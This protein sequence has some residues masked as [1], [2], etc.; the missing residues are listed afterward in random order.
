MIQADEIREKARKWYPSFLLSYLKGK[1]FFPK[2]IRFRKPGSSEILQNYLKIDKE[3]QNLLA[4]SKEAKGFGYT[5]IRTE[6][7]NHKLG[8]QLFPTRIYFET[9]Q[10]YLKFIRQEKDFET[11]IKCVELLRTE[12][13]QIEDW[14]LQHR[15]EITGYADRWEYLLKV[16][17][18][19]LMTPRPHQYLRELNIQV[20]TKFIEDNTGILMSLLDYLL[21]EEHIRNP[22]EK[23]NFAKRY[24]LKYSEELIRFRVLNAESLNDQLFNL[25]DLS[26]P[27][28]QFEQLDFPCK[29]V[30]VTENL[31]NF[32]TLPSY[33]D[34]I[35]IFGGG[36]HISL[37]KNTRWLE[38]KEIFY[39]GDIDTHG[40]QILS[41]FRFYFNQ[42]KSIMMDFETLN[43]YDA[44]LG[45]EKTANKKPIYILTE[46]EL[47]L[48]N[49]VL[50][51][52]LR[53][54]QEKI[55]QNYTRKMLERCLYQDKL[56]R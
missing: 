19:F 26:V 4:Q 3:I 17:K 53:L 39:W 38:E 55:D 2:D 22:A 47:A 37:L 43:A 32:L 7:K 29:R 54:E 33:Q 13:P 44:H 40:L 31:M 51:H 24:Y 28:S 50:K 30:F 49:H 14:I 11:F 6:R 16:C 48:Y 9:D 46:E 34:S 10:D 25:T 8:K 45:E 15:S 1:T 18:Y 23:K 36:F 42:V 20:H 52:R 35:V 27:V 56:E 5:V 12:L 41:E 21:T